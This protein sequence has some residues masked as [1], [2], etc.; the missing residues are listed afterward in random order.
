MSSVKSGN[1]FNGIGSI[2][3]IGM[4]IMLS[5]IAGYGQVA[6]DSTLKTTKLIRSGSAQEVQHVY[7][8]DSP[9]AKTY[10]HAEDCRGSTT[11]RLP[12]TG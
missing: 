12:G 9:T 10:H 11:D 8:C 7:V 4:L 6:T 2:F 1:L 5:R 3:T